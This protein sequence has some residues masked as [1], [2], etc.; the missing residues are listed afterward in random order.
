[1]DKLCQDVARLAQE[2]RANPYGR[3][4]AELQRILNRMR[5]TPFAG[6]LVLVQE[7]RDTPYRLAQLGATSAD[8][9]VYTGDIFATMEEAEWAVFKL[10]W[11]NLFGSDLVVE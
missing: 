8:P 1:M 11:R 10:R 2:F 3:H 9:I 4:S 5:N 6:R 7:E